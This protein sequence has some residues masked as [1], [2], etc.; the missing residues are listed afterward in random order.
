MILSLSDEIFTPD[1][2][3]IEVCQNVVSGKIDI[4]LTTIDKRLWIDKGPI[5]RGL[6][7]LLKSQHQ[8]LKVWQYANNLREKWKIM[9]V[10]IKIKGK[11]ISNF[12][13]SIA[14]INCLIK[15]FWIARSVKLFCLEILVDFPSGDPENLLVISPPV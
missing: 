4:I 6:E 9:Y 3:W 11:Y 7:L 14:V 8:E 5:L 1:W 15:K 12:I 10:W 2:L 13:F